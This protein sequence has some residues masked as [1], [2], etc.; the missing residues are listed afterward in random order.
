MNQTF[1]RLFKGQGYG[2][3]SNGRW[4][5]SRETNGRAIQFNKSSLY[6]PLIFSTARQHTKQWKVGDEFDLQEVNSNI[7][8]NVISKIL[9]GNDLDL[10]SSYPYLCKDTTTK[11]LN[12]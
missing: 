8:F 10:Q 3:I 11:Q 2:S 1:T 6:V 5:H 12:L 9:F 4:R 7:T